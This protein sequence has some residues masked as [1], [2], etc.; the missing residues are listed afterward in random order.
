MLNPWTTT[1]NKTGMAVGFTELMVFGG[2]LNSQ[3]IMENIRKKRKR[4]REG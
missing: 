3:I 4:H 1:I 2:V